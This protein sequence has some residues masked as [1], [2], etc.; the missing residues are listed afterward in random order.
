SDLITKNPHIPPTG[1]IPTG[2][3]VQFPNI[4]LPSSGNVYKAKGYE[5]FNDVVDAGMNKHGTQ[6]VDDF[7]NRYNDFDQPDRRFAPLPA[8]TALY[9]SETSASSMSFRRESDG[10]I[11]TWDLPFDMLA[12]EF[13]EKFRIR[14]SISQIKTELRHKNPDLPASGKIAIGTV[15]RLPDI[16]LPSEK[17]EYP[18]RGYET[19]SDVL[20][21]GIA[22]Y[23]AEWADKFLLRYGELLD[24]AHRNN[25]LASGT[26][27]DLS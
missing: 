16:Q 13:K 17:G 25:V 9:L 11:V 18:A 4:Q 21:A 10:I 20:N 2:T 27:L 12:S 24:D 3:I 7:L 26:K 1:T 23:G 22:M 19:F 8:G 14:D 5:S 15:I 6:W